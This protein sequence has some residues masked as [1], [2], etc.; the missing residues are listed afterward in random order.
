MTENANARRSFFLE[1]SSTKKIELVLKKANYGTDLQTVL[2]LS[3][4]D[5]A[6][7]QLAGK[8][9][10]TALENGAVPINLVYRTKKGKTQAAKVLCSPGKADTV[11]ND[12]KGKKYAGQ[13]IIEVRFPRR[14]VYTW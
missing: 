8:G 5:P 4:A 1:I 3:T 7:G 9:I 2:G 13:E 11:F 10:S 12:A 14:R 6:E